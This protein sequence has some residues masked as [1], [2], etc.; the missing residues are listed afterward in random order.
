MLSEQSKT[1][2]KIYRC[3][4]CKYTCVSISDYNKH[5]KTLKHTEKQTYNCE[6]GKKYKY[7]SG[8]SRHKKLCST[9]GIMVQERNYINEIIELMR[10]N[11]DLRNELIKQQEKLIQDSNVN[12]NNNIFNINMFLDN[13]CRN[14][15]TIQDFAR[16]LAVGIEDLEKT[17]KDC[18]M[19]ILLKN[20]QPMNIVDRPVHCTDLKKREWYVND[21]KTGWG[22]DNGEKL[23]KNTEYG[24]QINW[25]KEFNK[26]YPEW[27]S[28]EKLKDKYIEIVDTTASEM[29]TNLK[30]KLLKRISKDCLIP[31]DCK[32]L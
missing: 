11:K 5:L 2:P 32:Y 12:I 16:N 25:L 31:P 27:M 28:N 22:K 29:S 19:N 26:Q 20:L 4:Y 3:E 6:C 15:M 13:Q 1:K 17:K 7:K 21:E 9:G 23:L 8:L 24:I 30:T 14:A 18:M 10:E